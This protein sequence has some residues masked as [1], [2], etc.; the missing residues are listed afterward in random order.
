M[1]ATDSFLFHTY[2]SV[3]FSIQNTKIKSIKS[4]LL[5]TIFSFL[6]TVSA[7]SQV[8]FGIKGGPS[9]VQ[10]QQFLNLNLESGNPQSLPR[11]SY[12]GGVYLSKGLT[13][14]IFLSTELLFSSKGH[15]FEDLITTDPNDRGRFVLSYL[16]LPIFFDFR[17]SPKLSIQLGPEI[18][19]LLRTRTRQGT[20]VVNPRDITSFRD[21]D[22]GIV[23]GFQGQILPRTWVGMRFNQGVSSFVGKITLI[24]NRGELTTDV[25]RIVNQSLQ[26]TLSYDL[27]N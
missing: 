9:L 19:Y 4:R 25:L 21:W 18:G 26:M 3:Y 23:A 24:D 15:G 17:P 13:N 8:Q 6:L 11:V 27:I 16:N 5:T 10:T 12:Y 14:K 7:Y 1:D 20:S 2:R 22:L